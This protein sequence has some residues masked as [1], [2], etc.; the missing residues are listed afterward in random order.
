MFLNMTPIPALSFC[1]ADPSVYI[2]ISIR[3][4]SSS[5]SNTDSLLVSFTAHVVGIIFSY[6]S[7]SSL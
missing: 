1:I 5:S 2:S 6:I 4:Y 3:S 7:G